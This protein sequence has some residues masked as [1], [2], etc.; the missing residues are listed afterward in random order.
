MESR[1]VSATGPR[2]GIISPPLSRPVSRQAVLCFQ[3][4][5]PELRI[6]GR[7]LSKEEGERGLV[8]RA[9]KVED[10][11]GADVEGRTS[12]RNYHRVGPTAMCT[13]QVRI[14]CIIFDVDQYHCPI[15]KLSVCNAHCAYICEYLTCNH[16][17][18]TTTL[19]S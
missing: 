1:S 5:E 14:G 4:G 3:A 13:K 19:D 15:G 7:F 16:L 12:Y 11:S 18:P 8:G 6:F 10:N 2:C 9:V 17:F